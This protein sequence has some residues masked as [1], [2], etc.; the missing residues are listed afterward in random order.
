[1]AKLSGFRKLLSARFLSFFR[2]LMKKG[3][4][5]CDVA[6]FVATQEEPQPAQEEVQV[7]E[8]KA[9]P[10]KEKSKSPARGAKGIE[11]PVVLPPD[12]TALF[13]EEKTPH[14]NA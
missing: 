14:T 12:N 7:A 5:A 9:Q 8:N 13:D 4:L 11:H 1:M 2:Q 10:T 3:L 6:E